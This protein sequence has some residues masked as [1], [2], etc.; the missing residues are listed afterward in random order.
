MPDTIRSAA[1]VENRNRR[2]KSL[3]AHPVTEPHLWNRYILLAERRHAAY[4][5]WITDQTDDSEERYCQAILHAD[6]A[7]WI[8]RARGVK[9]EEVSTEDEDE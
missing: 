4:V 3:D 8:W 1:L 6:A 5:E 2:M 7:Y 9:I